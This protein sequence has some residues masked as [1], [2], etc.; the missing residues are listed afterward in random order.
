[1]SKI[2]TLH[3][4]PTLPYVLIGR[5]VNRAIHRWGLSNPGNPDGENILE[6]DWDNLI[7]LDACRYDYFTDYTDELPGNL[8]SATSVGSGTPEFIEAT[9]SDTE[10]LDLVYVSANSWWSF[11]KEE[12]N[13]SLHRFISLEEKDIQDDVFDVELPETVAKHALK[14]SDSYPNKRLLIHF[15]QPH[16]PHIGETGKRLFGEGSG[17]SLLS[18]CTRTQP[19]RAELQ[20]SYRETLEAAIPSVD[21]LLEELP[22]KTIVTADHGEMLKDR[23]SPIPTIDYGHSPGLYVPE[24]IRVPWFIGEFDERKEIIS[25]KPEKRNTAD[26]DA[27]IERLEK[28]GYR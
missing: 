13:S 6:K 8:Q 12:I 5:F 1:M 20:Q 3:S 4:R 25:E 27:V 9:F 22:G 17:E 23:L 11:L 16:H 21:R 15:N 2:E 28:L 19:N 24:L 10:L 18:A 14:A 7:I 26:D